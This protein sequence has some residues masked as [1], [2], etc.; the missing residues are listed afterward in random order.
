MAPKERILK[1]AAAVGD[2]VNMCASSICARGYYSAAYET[3]TDRSGCTGAGHVSLENSVRVLSLAGFC[4]E[5]T[6]SG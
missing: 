4:K 3:A 2:G 5:T 6:I 1:S